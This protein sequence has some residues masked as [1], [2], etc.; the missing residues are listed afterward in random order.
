[1]SSDPTRKGYNWR[2]NNNYRAE[3]G[4]L[5]IGQHTRTK[6]GK[7]VFDW[8]F[9]VLG[10]DEVIPLE[11]YMTQTSDEIE[12]TVRSH[13]LRQSIS[14][15]DIN[16]LKDAVE[17]ELMEQTAMISGLGW[18]DWLEVIVKGDNSDRGDSPHSATG[19]NLH[20]QVN[21]LKRGVDEA[22]R[23]FTINNNGVVTPFPTSQDYDKAQTHLGE[24]KIASKEERSYIPATPDNLMAI[25]EIMSRMA[26][27]RRNLARILSQEAI[28]L[29]LDAIAKG[30]PL[31][32]A[33]DINRPRLPSPG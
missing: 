14:D 32:D 20:I 9:K 5:D 3:T 1:M 15:S 12:F 22:G 19:A 11:V 26:T 33:P 29:Q 2:F 28:H 21:H 8:K 4:H 6:D 25:E 10:S 17:S 31:L 30:I 7:K 23:A 27:L 13:R 24:F 16:R 18:Q